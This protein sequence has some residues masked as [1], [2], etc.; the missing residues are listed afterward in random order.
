MF[1]SSTVLFVSGDGQGRVRGKTHRGETTPRRYDPRVGRGP[2]LWI[3]A[4]S[5]TSGPLLHHIPI[6]NP[7]HL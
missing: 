2:S 7:E 4:S 6:P 5:S 3:W 1:I